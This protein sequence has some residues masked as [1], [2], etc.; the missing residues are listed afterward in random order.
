M[1]E[2][3]RSPRRATVWFVEATLLAMLVSCAAGLLRGW[4]AA[5][6]TMHFVQALGISL[7]TQASLYYH[8]LY[9]TEHL[10]TRRLF[11]TT[12]RALAM[13]AVVLWTVYWMAPEAWS[14]GPVF[15]VSLGAAALVL[16]AWRSAF[17]R[18][19][20]SE[21]LCSRAV[22]LGSGEL[23][24]ACAAL[25]R[26]DREAGLRM[27]GRLVRD[28]EPLTAADSIGRFRDLVR[29]VEQY[30]VCRVIVACT[31]RRGGFPVDALLELKLRGVEI[32]EGI[33]FYERATGRIFVKE[34]KPSH[35]IFSR[36]YQVRR[37]TLLAKRVFDV[38]CA[39]AGLVLALPL[40]VLTAI[41]IKID[42]P[43]PVLYSQT[44]TGAFGK[45]FRIHKFR[46]MRTDAEKNGAV[47][48]LEDDPRVTRVGRF[49]RKT[50]LDELPQLWNVLVGEMSMVG[51]RPERP[52]FIA[53][54]EQQI[55]FFRQR[56][57]V[58]PG[59]TGHAQVRCRYGASLEDAAEKLQYDLYYMK[60]M[61]LW[62]DLSILMDT[63]KVVL[64]RIGAR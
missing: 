7:V 28:D 60:S 2:V 46:S 20:R 19:S 6:G 61:S 64:L 30:N 45:N 33:D 41:A 5:L 25:V 58:K 1:L 55:P 56:L 47:W 22:V 36:G 17:D 40:M 9:D 12:F 27:I 59:I 43:G 15:L 44:R 35:I 49:I 50:R 37:R 57:C 11:V 24:Q 34:L 26:E 4:D 3:F 16:P 13:A 63:V 42:S 8:G 62:F 21:S 38:A 29:I 10:T 52:E 23:A 39:G 32:E 18:V 31:E 48:A 51:P 14:V 54:L 53:T